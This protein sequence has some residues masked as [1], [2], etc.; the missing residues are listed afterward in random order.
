MQLFC[1]GQDVF[2]HARFGRRVLFWDHFTQRTPVVLLLERALGLRQIAV[3]DFIRQRRFSGLYVLEKQDAVVDLACFLVFL[4][5]LIAERRIVLDVHARFL[6][7]TQRA[8]ALDRGL[9]IAA[10]ACL[11]TACVHDV[12]AAVLVAVQ[13]FKGGNGLVIPSGHHVRDSLIVGTP[14][15]HLLGLVGERGIG[16]DIDGG[17]LETV[18]RLERL[19]CGFVVAAV[20]CLNGAGVGDVFC[21]VLVIV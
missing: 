12:F 5:C 6:E 16:R 3:K 2:I 13:R 9:V 21:A 1:I 8:Q 18:Q 10:V 4:L 19:D 14:Y 7:I 11:Q 15:S 17:L 20:A